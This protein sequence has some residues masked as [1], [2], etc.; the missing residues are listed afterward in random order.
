MVVLALFVVMKLIDLIILADVMIGVVL[1]ASVFI[2]TFFKYSKYFFS[3]LC[4]FA[5]N[6]V[7]SVF[8]FFALGKSFFDKINDASVQ[9][10]EILNAGI[11]KNEEQQAFFQEMFRTMEII[12]RKYY[13]GIWV[14]VMTIAL[15]LGIL[16][17]SRKMSVKWKHKEVRIEFYWI[18]GLIA[19]LALFVFEGSRTVAINL[20]LIILPIFLIEG[21]SMIDFYW[22]NYFKKSKLLLYV[23]IIAIVLNP[24]LLG[25]IM[26]MGLTDVWFNY[27]KIIREEIDENH[28]N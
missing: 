14:F 7:Y 1:A 16:L 6:L 22:G 2:Y 4:A 11:I 26:L 9:Y 3:F 21:F 5:V 27:R 25:L 13:L 18:Y 12:V 23:M 10:M 28:P 19:S 24:Y 15:Y 8:R 20:L 17:F